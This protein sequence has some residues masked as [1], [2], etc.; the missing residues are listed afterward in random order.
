[1]NRVAKLSAAAVCV[2]ASALI[3]QGCGDDEDGAADSGTDSGGDQA[4]RG[5]SGGRGGAGGR[6]G[7]G[8]RG[9]QS[10]GQGSDDDA[11]L[12][13][14]SV[15]IR[16]KAKIGDEDLACGREYDGLGSSKVQAT[17]Q[18]FRF[19]VESV[20]LISK[21]GAEVPVRFDERAPF[22][23]KDVA[24]L[25]FTDGQG[26]C[27]PGATTNTT[28]TGKVPVGDYSGIVFVNG[29]PESI[30]HQNIAVAKPPL[31]DASTYWGWQSGYRFI[32]AELLPTAQPDADAGVDPT[33]GASFVHIGTG[34]CTGANATGF[35]CA[36]ANRNAIKLD[37]F[38]PETD[39]VVADLGKVFANV[40]LETGLE[41]HGPSPACNALY[42]ALGLELA[43][44]KA[45][46]AQEVFRVE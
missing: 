2:L 36:R 37:D 8:G 16:F 41:C 14:R 12:A 13:E 9:G 27:A 15:T 7:A 11:G 10:A 25:D 31:Q 32:M 39:T 5:G 38:D 3:A 18:D 22:Q 40:N 28:I 4:G 46:D 23:T 29:V 26:S 19:F 44:G 20:K 17:P 35:T 24:F 21:D 33:G 42:S 6:S 45:L 34:G 43:T 30:N 1:M